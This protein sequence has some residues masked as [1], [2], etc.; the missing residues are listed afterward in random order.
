MNLNLIEQFLLISLDDDEGIFIADVNHLY[1]GIAGALLIELA[2]EEKIE[3]RENKLILT[4]KP[5]SVDP[6]INQSINAF[7]NEK[8][9]KVGFW[10]DAFKSNGKEIKN[11]TLDELI[12]K[13]ILRREK[14]KIL[15]VIPYEK[16]PTENPIPE[17]KVRARIHNIVINDTKPTVKDLMLLS[18]IDVCKLTREAFRDESAYK[19]A[20]KK[21]YK[22]A[23]VY[24]NPQNSG[25]QLLNIESAI[26]S[27]TR[28]AVLDPTSALV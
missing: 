4:G 23:E 1:Y 14:G 13:G 11:F 6:L 17:N 18:L 16:Y 24:E 12:S 8:D 5:D 22:L 26:I 7:E 10:I 9:R 21:I 19:I 3:L 28:L 20:T 27:T 25:D 15:W 2:L